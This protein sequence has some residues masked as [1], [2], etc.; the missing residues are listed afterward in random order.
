MGKNVEQGWVKLWRK[1]KDKGF[2]R[3]STYIHL[4]I[5]LLLSANHQQKEFVWN[6]NTIII[7]E[8]QL[9]TG[10]KELSEQ[11]GIPQTTIERILNYL[12][13]EHQIGQQKTTKYRL[14]TIINW[15][16]YQQMDSKVDNKRTTNGQQTDTNKNDKNNNND[17]NIYMSAFNQFWKEYPKKELKKKSKEI[18]KQKGLDSKL[19]EILEFIEKAKSTE[20]W[21]KGFIKQPPTFL[22]ND[23]WEDDL[24]AYGKSTKQKEEGKYKNIKQTTI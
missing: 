22:G 17:K 5:H 11:T 18:W 9:L 24:S 16:D 3:K 13:N 8:G 6:G 21:Q 19:G 15:K 2:Y 7:K 1:L 10:R 14:I 23:C 4:W 20:R 12:E